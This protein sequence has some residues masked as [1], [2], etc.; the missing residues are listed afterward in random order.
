MLINIYEYLQQLQE[1]CAPTLSGELVWVPPMFASMQMFVF[2]DKWVED[3]F[4]PFWWEYMTVYR[5]ERN[6]PLENNAK[7]GICDEI[8]ERCM[9]HFSEAVRKLEGDTDCRAGA[10]AT[11]VSLPGGTSVNDVHG[12]GGHELICLATT[13]DQQTVKLYL[14]EPQNR[15]R[16]ALADAVSAGVIVRSQWV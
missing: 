2:D 10:I 12:P 5:N 16:T 3:E 13:K 15:K 1:E 8:T 11:R 9:S 7:R 6:Q 4:N 14:Y